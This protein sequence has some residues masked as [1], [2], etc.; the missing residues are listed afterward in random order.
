M[1]NSD[2]AMNDAL[3]ESVAYVVVGAGVHG[4]STAWHL[5]MER[6]ARGQGSGAEVIVLIKIGAKVERHGLS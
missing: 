4:L 3:P 6:A 5:A 1:T 2:R